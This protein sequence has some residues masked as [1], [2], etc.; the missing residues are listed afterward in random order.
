[1]TLS[2]SDQVPPVGSKLIV[3]TDCDETANNDVTGA[4]GSIY[5]IEIDNS[6]N[7][8]NPAFLKIYDAAAPTIGT[9]NPDWQ[10]KVP[11]NQE[12]SVT[13]PQG[14][15]FSVALS[16]ACVTTGGTPG[17]TGPTNAVIVRMVTS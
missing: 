17:T 5:Q 7:S 9:T 12:R 15:D 4:A 16:F 14:L 3:Q 1:M 10:V 2:V 6:A 8:D 11:V 13:I